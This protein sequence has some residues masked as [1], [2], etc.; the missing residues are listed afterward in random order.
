MTRKRP[1]P[2]I[3]IESPVAVY[4]QI[5]DALRASLVEAS[6][7]GPLSTRSSDPQGFLVYAFTCCSVRLGQRYAVLQ[8]KSM[9]LENKKADQST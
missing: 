8:R 7:A 9:A 5:V 6:S 4:R 1:R 3:D 2:Q